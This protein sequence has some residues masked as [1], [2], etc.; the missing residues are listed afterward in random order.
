MTSLRATVAM[1]HAFSILPLFLGVG[2]GGLLVLC[3][4]NFSQEAKDIVYQHKSSESI[5][6]TMEPVRQRKGRVIM[7]S[8]RWQ[9]AANPGG[10]GFL[11][12]TLL[13]LLGNILPFPLASSDQLKILLIIGK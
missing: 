11:S 10:I 8:S 6:L 1:A 7:I 3:P 9:P 13:G 5:V 4:V 12:P 2:M